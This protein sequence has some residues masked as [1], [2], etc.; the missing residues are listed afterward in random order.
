M[1]PLIDAQ[2]A[3]LRRSIEADNRI[4]AIDE[5]GIAAVE[6]KLDGTVVHANDNFLTLMGYSLRDIVGQH[7]RMFV[8]ADFAQ[9]T[10]YK[11]FWNDLNEGIP[12]P[13]RYERKRKDGSTVIIQGSYSI[14][15]DSD[16]K[17][18][19]ILKLANDITSLVQVQEKSFLQNGL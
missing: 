3:M 14:F 11:K 16:G 7:H 10:E 12:R 8:H 17:P 9:S 19:G 15:R 5:S 13:G 6:F 2:Q 1:T 18:V 4:K